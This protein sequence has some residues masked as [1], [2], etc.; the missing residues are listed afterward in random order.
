MKIVSVV[1]DERGHNRLVFTFNLITFS[2]Y[3]FFH[4]YSDYSTW[5][6]CTS[7]SQPLLFY[8]SSQKSHVLYPNCENWSPFFVYAL[9]I[10]HAIFEITNIF[11]YS[12]VT[13]C[14]YQEMCT[15]S[16]PPILGNNAI[17]KLVSYLYNF[18]S[19][20]PCDAICY[21]FIINSRT[22]M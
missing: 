4:F 1:D 11:F 12:I 19:S 21:K 7:D 20:Y 3:E 8:A 17:Q 10:N 2:V 6:R 9:Q 15:R 18:K 13:S 16:P 22:D 14:D 5:I